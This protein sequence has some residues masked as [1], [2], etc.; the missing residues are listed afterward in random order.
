MR[1]Q[2]RAR[3]VRHR[4]RRL[5]CE[6]R[7][8]RAYE[9]ID[10]IRFDGMQYPQGHRLTARSSRRPDVDTVSSTTTSRTCK[11]RIVAALE[12]IDGKPFRTRRLAATGRRRRHHAA[13]SRKATCSSAAASISRTCRARKLPPSAT[14]ARPQLA[15]RAL[16]A[17]GVSLVLHPR[18]PILPDRAPERAFLR[19]TAEATTRVV[20]RRRH[21][22]HALLRLR[23]GRAPFPRDLQDGA[24][25]VRRRATIRASRNG[26]TNISTSGTATSRAASAA[27]SSTTSP[28]RISTFFRAGA[29]RRRPLP[30]RLRAD[31]RAP[32]GRC[33]TAS[34]SATSRRTGAAATSSSTWS[35][36]AARCS[37]CSRAAAPSRS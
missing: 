9:A 8:T 17:M 4:A 33:P 20:V 14:A 24:G 19:C 35:T 10:R 13:S 3:A 5:A 2:R 25:A 23:G 22:P 29:K 7:S 28:S 31:P 32:Q 18:N 27:S 26:A 37:A 6:W 30:R 36:T 15:G 1:D 16:E 12:A 11:Q 34:A 21:G